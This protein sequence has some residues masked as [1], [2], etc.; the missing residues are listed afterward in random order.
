MAGFVV[1]GHILKVTWRVAKYDD[2]YS[3]FVLCT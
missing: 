2:P 3:E 1:Q